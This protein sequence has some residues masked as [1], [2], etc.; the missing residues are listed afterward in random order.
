MLKLP[1]L[2]D[3][4][5]HLR[6]PG[7][8]HK[9]DFLSGTSAAL[10]GGY[11]TIIDMP[12]NLQPITTIKK[13]DEKIAI[14]KDQIICDVGFHFGSLGENFEQFP[15]VQNKVVGLKVYLNQTTGGF[16]VDEKVFKKICEAWPKN[17]P[18]IVHAESDVIGSIIEIANQEGQKLHIAHVSSQ[19]ELQAIITAKQKGYA[20]TCG[21]TPHHLF[22]TEENMRTLGPFALM[23]PSLKSKDDVAFLW[24]HM[25]D[26]DIIES[27]HAPHTKA[28]KEGTNPPFG[29]TG[30]ETT[31]SLL[32]TAAGEGKLTIDTIKK[33]CY[34]SPAK[35]FNITQDIQTYVEVDEAEQWI[36]ENE[37]LFTKSQWSPFNGWKLQGKVKTVYV[38]GQK[39]FENGKILA[40]P[41]TGKIIS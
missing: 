21:V 27:D 1:G 20:V 2:I 16:I 13:L 7:Q 10:A 3:P 5:V 18:I 19:I 38:R 24:S 25:Q 11:T 39:V 17:H 6:T 41:G 30:L 22:L 37:K 8:S 4:H 33:L 32:L 34:E 28:E 14:A 36:V 15:L 29:V 12:N 26:I 35:I 31:L 9:E 40:S 23:K